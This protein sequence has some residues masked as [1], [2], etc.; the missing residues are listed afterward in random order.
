MEWWSLPISNRMRSMWVLHGKTQYNPI[1][2]PFPRLNQAKG[3]F[4]SL[5]VVFF[6][7]SNLLLYFTLLLLLGVLHIIFANISESGECLWTFEGYCWR[8]WGAFLLQS[9]F[10]VWGNVSHSYFWL[11]LSLLLLVELIWHLKEYGCCQTTPSAVLL[12]ISIVI[13]L[14]LALFIGWL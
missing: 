8:S 11:N 3:G 7:C 9:R 14:S 10:G 12:L 6:L 1:L 2:P 13:F 4:I 5:V